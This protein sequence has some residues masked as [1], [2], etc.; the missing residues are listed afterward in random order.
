MT[1]RW[2]ET[3]H[4]LR[5]WT[6]G[7]ASSERLAA[8]IL[9]H[10]KYKDL[11]P[12]HPMGG[13][14][15]IKDAV[16]QKDGQDWLMAVYFPRGQQNFREI[17]KKFLNDLKGVKLNKVDALAFVTNQELRL[18]E[19]QTLHK[20]SGKISVE[21]F[22][23]ERIT[24]ILDQP[25]M[26]VVRK[27]FLGIDY[28][29]MISL[30]LGG[31]GGEAP[32]AG[33]GGGGVLGFGGQGGDGGCGGNVSLNGQPGQAPGGGG[34]GGGAIGDKAT[35]GE[36]GEGGEVIRAFFRAEEIP[37]TVEIKIGSGGRGG[38]N[39]GTGEDGGD[40]IFGNL[41]RAKGGRG[42]QALTQAQPLF[43]KSS[44]KE[45]W[46]SSALLA[47]YAE[48]RDGLLYTLGCGWEAYIV[49][50]FPTIVHGYFL[51]VVE[52]NEVK[53]ETK[54]ELFIKIFNSEYTVAFESSIYVDMQGVYKIVRQKIV[55]PFQVEVSIPGIWS[56]QILSG[57]DELVQVPFEICKAY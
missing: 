43:G 40:T 39:G 17:K 22:H 33:G 26:A 8:Q 15:G 12:S 28:A 36:G 24:T 25:E 9:L 16:C 30:L 31:R 41:L 23:L 20:A 38:E 32:G 5:E 10:Q 57:N 19:R 13:K 44:D 54:Q 3:W 55:F 27:Q 51:F 53:P 1:N 52:S 18:A 21:L 2:D 42:G 6:N 47:N 29:E 11:D 37:D 46:I 4:R 49:P 45:I 7:Q 14:D 56:I 48:I 35:A 34:G 50:D